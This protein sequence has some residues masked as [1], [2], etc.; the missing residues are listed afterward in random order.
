[1]EPSSNDLSEIQIEI[2]SFGCQSKE[3]DKNVVAVLHTYHRIC[4]YIHL[5]WDVDGGTKVI[6]FLAEDD[7]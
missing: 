1:M 3:A 4:T 2:F 7:R 5:V 6:H